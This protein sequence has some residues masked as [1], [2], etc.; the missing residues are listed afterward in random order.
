MLDKARLSALQQKKGSNGVTVENESE[1]GWS[2]D[3]FSPPQSQITTTI[4]SQNPTNI[5]SPNISPT[6]S[7]TLSNLKTP[8]SRPPAVTKPPPVITKKTDILSNS[9]ESPVSKGICQIL[10]EF[11]ANCIVHLIF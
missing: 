6:N 3:D 10:S 9:N 7:N 11:F 4:N 1:E 2:D 5:N 8:I